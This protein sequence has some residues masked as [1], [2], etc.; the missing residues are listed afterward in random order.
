MLRA[1]YKVA[2]LSLA[3]GCSFNVDRSNIYT[4]RVLAGEFQ[5]VC[6][7]LLRELVDLKLW[8]DD[9]KNRIIANNGSIQAIPEIP[10]DIKAIYKTV[11]EISQKKVL[12]L[13]ADRGAF[14]CQSQSLNVHLQAPTAGQLTS[15]HFY[16]WKRGLKTGM[17]YLRTRPAAQAIQFTLDH[18]LVAQVKQQK[19]QEEV[20]PVTKATLV[21]RPVT[22]TPI[23]PLSYPSIPSEVTTRSAISPVTAA[24]TEPVVATA[25]PAT[26][27]SSGSMPAS[28]QYPPTPTDSHD[29]PLVGLDEVQR[30]AAEKDPE[31]AAAVARRK[32]RELE[33]AKLAC[34][35]ENKEA[36]V[37]CSG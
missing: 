36:C 34:S 21:K 6:P 10:T 9:M 13:A 22:P 17:Y 31:F 29:D 8:N 14:I 37:M 5:V 4:R 7:W 33:E 27:T 30:R 28:P 25:T 26:A 3:P 12:D 20:Q 35:L 15:M 24:A 2:F 23:A 16:G 19:E 32:A 11:W 18:S 1:V